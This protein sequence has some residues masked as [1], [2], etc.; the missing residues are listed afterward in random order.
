M[1]NKEAKVKACTSKTVEEHLSHYPKVQGLIV[2]LP[3]ALGEKKA[4]LR[5]CNIGLQKQRSDR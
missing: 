2:P 1:C 4:A 3:L 5:C